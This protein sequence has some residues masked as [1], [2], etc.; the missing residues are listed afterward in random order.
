MLNG[1]VGMESS[2]NI[3]I[4]EVKYMFLWTKMAELH[5][6]CDVNRVVTASLAVDHAVAYHNEPKAI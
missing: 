5:H 3:S 1:S 6:S 2:V 4:C